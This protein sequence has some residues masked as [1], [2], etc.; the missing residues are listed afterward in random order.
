MRI[1]PAVQK[2]IYS[3]EYAAILE[4]LKTQRKASGLTMRQLAERLDVHHSWVGRVELGERRLDV[5]EFVRYCQALG[6]NPLEGL[7]LIAQT[8]K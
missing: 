6:A 4:W 5:V 8:P 2:T 1:F 7:N 3:N